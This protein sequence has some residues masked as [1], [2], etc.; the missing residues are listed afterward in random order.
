MHSQED[1]SSSGMQRR[2]S[3]DSKISAATSEEEPTNLRDSNP[4]VRQALPQNPAKQLRRLSKTPQQM[5]QLI[6]R[7]D[8]R[9][10]YTF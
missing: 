1:E 5:L 2:I 9:L 7:E 4:I 10:V 3:V 8:I 6:S